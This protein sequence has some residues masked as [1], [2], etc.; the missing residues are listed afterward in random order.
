MPRRFFSSIKIQYTFQ[1][2]KTIGFEK[3]HHSG[4]SPRKT[5]WET[6]SWVLGNK[7]AHK[8]ASVSRGVCLGDHTLFSEP[9][10]RRE[11]R[12]TLTCLYQ[13]TSPS[14]ASAEN[15][16]FSPNDYG[17][18]KAPLKTPF[19]TPQNRRPRWQHLNVLLNHRLIRTPGNTRKTAANTESGTPP[20]VFYL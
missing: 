10:A 14:P 4:C 17:Q 5:R 15:T 3:P 20:C 16:L 13:H 2:E 7:H 6:I 11:N 18:T 8:L 1:V 9:S 19:Q 12:Q